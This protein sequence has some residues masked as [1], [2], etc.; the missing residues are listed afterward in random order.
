MRSELQHLGSGVKY[1][2]HCS[3]VQSDHKHHGEQTG[4]AGGQAGVTEAAGGEEGRDERH[5]RGGGELCCPASA[6]QTEATSQAS[7]R[8]HFSGS[9]D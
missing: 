7:F 3:G 8:A 6:E 5:Q 9:E 2:H 1:F 4:S